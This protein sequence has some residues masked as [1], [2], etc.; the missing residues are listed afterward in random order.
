[1]NLTDGLSLSSG[2]NLDF[3]LN[4]TTASGNDLVSITGASGTVNYRRAES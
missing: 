1:M 2:A 4:T 3:N